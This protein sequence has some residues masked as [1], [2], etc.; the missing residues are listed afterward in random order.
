MAITSPDPHLHQLLDASL[1]FPPETR[2]A[3][4]SHLPMA[5]HALRG[6]GASDERLD[7]FFAGYVRRFEVPLPSEPAAAAADWQALCGQPDS[8]AALRATFAAALAATSTAAVLQAV[9]PHLL[10]GA[11]AAAFHGPIRVAHAVESGHEGELAAALAYWAWR[12]QPVARPQ[13]ERECMDFDEWSA[14]LVSAAPGFTPEAPLIAMRMQLAESAPAYQALAGALRP[15]ARTLAQLTVF[16]AQRYA[17]T[18]SF[19]V[20]HMVTGLRALRLLLPLAG[21][22]ADDAHARALVHACTAAYLAARMSQ[23]PELPPAT[24][25]SWPEL[26]AQA[27]A[28][29]DDHVIKIVHA[30]RQ[31]DAQHGHPAFRAAA[32]QALS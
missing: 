21:A 19:T 29:E 14:Q 2:T 20:L 26:M 3:L 9:L 22:G 15:D 5:L 24:E 1:H 8:F 18:R 30:C 28:S 10:H 4:S 6:L 7:G 17:A 16:A 23:W 27:C 32:S 31:L 12:W 11:A 13:L 25:R